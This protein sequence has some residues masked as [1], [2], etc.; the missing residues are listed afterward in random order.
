MPQTPQS[1]SNALRASRRVLSVAVALNYGYAGFI[2]AVVAMLTINRDWT[3]TAIGI[4]ESAPRD[5]LLVGM[6]LLAGFGMTGAAMMHRILRRLQA[7]VATVQGGDPFVPENAVRLQAIA[8]GAVWLELLHLGVG[9]VASLMDSPAQPF[10]VDWNFSF[11]P[12]VAVLMLFVLARVFAH[13]TR[14][15]DDLEGVV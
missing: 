6:L 14:L 4:R 2:V 9:A 15:R 12:W 11:T 7:I 1:S 3:M 5:S 8:W 13:G 10:D